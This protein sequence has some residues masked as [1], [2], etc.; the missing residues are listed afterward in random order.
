[1][2]PR[3]TKFNDLTYVSEVFGESVEDF[4][5]TEFTVVDEDDVVYYGQLKK[6]KLT[7]S[8]EEYEAALQRVPDEDL[9]PL[10]PS[11]AK[12]TIAP[13]T[14]NDDDAIYL[15][16]PRIKLCNDYKEQNIMHLLPQMVLDEAR[17]LETIAKHPHHLNI[18]GY[19]GCRVRRGHITALVLDRHS[20]NLKEYLR[21]NLGPL[22]KAK[23]MAALESAIQHLHSIGLAHNDINPGNILIDHNGNPV[24]IDFGSCREIGR[25]LGASRGTSG[26]IEGEMADYTTSEARH[27][28]F[29]L[30][31]IR[32]WL[33]NPTPRI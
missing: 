19:H 11:D 4:L 16:R 30:E 27:D 20:H 22:D 15:K 7:I 23:F 12:F 9:Y 32:A 14:P 25:E 17:A 28:T 3:I 33:E 24:L 1:M 6:A 10:L 13:K 2:A 18:I 29:A 5:Y 8:L 31:K 26:W 21:D